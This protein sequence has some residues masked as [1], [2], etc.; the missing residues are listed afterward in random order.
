VN[1]AGDDRRSRYRD[2]TDVDGFEILLSG[3]RLVAAARQMRRATQR[4]S[5][6]LRG[7]PAR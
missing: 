5:A 3:V 2:N 6:A 7:S 1:Y 4:T